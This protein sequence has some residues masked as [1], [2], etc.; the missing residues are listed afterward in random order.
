MN[1][2]TQA[3]ERIIFNSDYICHGCGEK[4]GKYRSGVHTASMG[5]C[6]ICGKREY[7]MPQRHYGYFLEN[8]EKFE[9]RKQEI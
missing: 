5:D 2:S 6:G 3:P 7:L 9:Y 1:S 4:Y 8:K